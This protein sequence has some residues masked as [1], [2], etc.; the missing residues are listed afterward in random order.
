MQVINQKGIAILYV[1]F[2]VSVLLAISFGISEILISQVKMLG[3]IGYSVVALY[4]ADSGI[5]NALI[6]R[7]SPDPTYDG[8]LSADIT[9]EVSVTEGGASEDCTIDF[10]YCIKSIGSYKDIKRAIEVKY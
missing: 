1:I 9:Y 4:A 5:E 10:Y 6:D 3:D 7:Q 8:S 2:L